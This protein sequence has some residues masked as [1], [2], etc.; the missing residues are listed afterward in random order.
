MPADSLTP[1]QEILQPTTK[2]IKPQRLGPLCNVSSTS[3]TVGIAVT[4]YNNSSSIT[5]TLLSIANQLRVPDE[6]VVADDCS[7]DDTLEKI[8]D[9]K[10]NHPQLP[11]RIISNKNN[12]GIS[13]N[14]D[15]AI[16]SLNSTL[17][18]HL[19][20]DD[21]ISPLKIKYESRA[22]LNEETLVSFS[23][24]KVVFKESCS[25]INTRYYDKRDSDSI[26]AAMISRTHPV[27]R[28]LMM[29][30]DLYLS[31]GGFSPKINLYEDWHHKQRMASKSNPKSWLH[32]G[33]VGTSYY[34]TNPGLSG[35]DPIILLAGQLKAMILNIDI[36]YHLASKGIA[37]SLNHLC[38]LDKNNE[39]PE[40]TCFLRRKDFTLEHH[41]LPFLDRM[42]S[43]W[44]LINSPQFDRNS[45]IVYLNSAVS[46]HH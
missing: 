34:R 40:L 1:G 26:M 35:R 37:L 2:K 23:D 28:D 14:R 19:D 11:I 33:C 38:I 18:T 41:L 4:T 43:D 16:R 27:P 32:S 31:S 12:M 36:I 17:V 3:H 30:K 5:N 7:T 42:K 24:T 29:R 21:L 39:L 44:D 13:K 22:F 20:G 45:A 25:I 8:R 6:I 9:F 10:N 15:N 46:S